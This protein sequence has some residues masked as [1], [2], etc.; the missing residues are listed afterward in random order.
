M[1]GGG[2]ADAEAVTE[3][4]EGDGKL[5]EHGRGIAPGTD[6]GVAVTDEGGEALELDDD[7]GAGGCA[8]G[9]ASMLARALSNCWRVIE[10]KRFAWCAGAWV[11]MTARSSR[12]SRIRVVSSVGDCWRIRARR[13]R[14]IQG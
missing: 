14:V 12:H 4:V 1:G 13:A 6:A 3:G 9:L 5:V 10:W 2:G 11:R 7:L 8:A